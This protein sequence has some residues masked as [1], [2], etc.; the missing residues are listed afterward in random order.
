MPIPGTYETHYYGATPCNGTTDYQWID[1]YVPTTA[2]TPAVPTGT[3]VPAVMMLSA[4][5]FSSSPTLGNAQGGQ[6]QDVATNGNCVVFVVNYRGPLISPPDSTGNVPGFPMEVLDAMSG[7]RW[8]M[9]N[10]A[11]WNAETT[12]LHMIAGSAGGTIAALATAELLD[13]GYNIASCQV[14]SS[15]HDFWAAYNYYRDTT[16]N[17]EQ[18]ITGVT[19]G[20]TTT[21]LTVFNTFQVGQQ[22]T[23]RVLPAGISNLFLNVGYTVTAVTPSGAGNNTAVTL[24]V[25]TTGTYTGTGLTAGVVG[26]HP[27]WTLGQSG[28][29][30]HLGNIANAYGT[31]RILGWST[32]SGSFSGAGN[33]NCLEWHTNYYGVSLTSTDYWGPE[34]F[35]RY[36]PAFRCS[37]KASRCWWQLWNSATEEIPL[38]QPFLM[39]EALN[40]VGTMA[41]V[42]IIPGSRHSWNYWATVNDAVARFPRQTQ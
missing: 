24:A 21:T 22:C 26:T 2:G 28:A 19:H 18:G 20:A 33:V 3:P 40:N 23:F 13:L 15:N 11:T 36:S 38:Q 35:A 16:D 42:N 6:A 14:L 17:V 32:A 39:A 4:S 41:T 30:G 5:G 31:T 34:Y 10:A 8:I 27:E 25:A 7:A 12:A 9:R 29:A 1:V 37:R